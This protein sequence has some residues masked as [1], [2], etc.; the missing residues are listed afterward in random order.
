MF[1]GDADAPIAKAAHAEAR[2]DQSLEEEDRRYKA[3]KSQ[4]TNYPT[5]RDT[6]K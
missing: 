1:Q 3:S 2:V 5:G 6:E 4:R